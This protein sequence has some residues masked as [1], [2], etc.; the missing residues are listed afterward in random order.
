MGSC[1]S[2]TQIIDSLYK[3]YNKESDKIQ[4]AH[5]C[6]KIMYQYTEQMD[7]ALIAYNNFISDF[8]K[9][10]N[11][12]GLG[13]ANQ[14]MGYVALERSKYTESKKYYST[15][16]NLFE[17][18]K[19]DT[20]IGSCY[21]RMGFDDYSLGD[22]EKSITNYLRSIELFEKHH[23]I[24]K[25]AWSYN[26]MGLSL[27]SKPNPNYDKALYYYFKALEIHNSLNLRKNNGYILLRIGSTYRKL[28]DYEKA[29]DYLIDALKLSDSL[30]NIGVEMWSLEG[31]TQLYKDKKEYPNALLYS[32]KTLQIALRGG[33][34]NPGIVIA[35]RNLAEM[36]HLLGN[37]EKAV[38]SIDSSIYY[39]LANNIYQTLPEIYLLKSNI[40]ESQKNID[41]S[42]RYY[43][44]Y[45]KTKDSL[46]NAQNNKNINDLEAAFNN[47]EK[48]KEI[49]YLNDQKAAD[50]KIKQTLTIAFILSLVLILVS[51]YALI[52]IN[53]SK[54]LLKTKNKEIE[55]Q[56]SIVEEK[57]KAIIDSIKYAK[58]IQTAVMTN[59]TYIH[60]NIERLTKKD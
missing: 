36:N 10:N 26:L 39:S 29:H 1:D 52:K 4:K 31:L 41:G 49:L 7:S 17:Q 30:K 8:K 35:Y 57:Q 53:S 32:Q 58:R 34:D 55:L 20:M 3:L 33:F 59:E 23:A 16:I 48:E 60:K 24:A 40:Y 54:K 45:V 12:F 27:Y 25:L 42:F 50:K 38:L 11:I 13:A 2:Q 37:H 6:N 56:K 22:Y 28:K 18:I 5:L 47:K 15:A 51:I 44:L 9:E 19:N 43:K 14:G 46:F 21:S